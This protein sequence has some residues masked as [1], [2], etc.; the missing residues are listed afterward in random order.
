ML[1]QYGWEHRCKLYR[2][3]IQ[4]SKFMH[5][6]LLGNNKNLL[7]W[8]WCGN[9]SK[10]RVRHGEVVLENLINQLRVRN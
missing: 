4:S 5:R 2:K 10:I 7:T 3:S 1:M 8:E 6:K 9:K